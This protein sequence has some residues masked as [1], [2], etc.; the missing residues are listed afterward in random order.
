MDDSAL[1][2]RFDGYDKNGDGRL[3]LSEF[4]Q[5]LDELG[6]GYEAAQ[7]KSAFESLDADQDGVMGFAEFSGWW[8]D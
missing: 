2:A 3:E 8:V 5:L 1:R 4:A 7:V 6:A